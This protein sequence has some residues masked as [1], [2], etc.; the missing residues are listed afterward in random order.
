MQPLPSDWIPLP[1]LYY[2]LIK[3]S[4]LEAIVREFALVLHLRPLVPETG[5]SGMDM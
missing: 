5:I 2:Y 1:L 3:N 4:R